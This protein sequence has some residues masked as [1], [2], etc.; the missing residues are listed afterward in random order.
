MIPMLGDLAGGQFGG[1]MD[2]NLFLGKR[3]KSNTAPFK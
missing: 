2:L 3:K 1:R